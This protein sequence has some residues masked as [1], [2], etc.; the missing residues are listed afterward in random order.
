MRRLSLILGS[1]L[2][3]VLV[4]PVAADTTGPSDPPPAFSTGGTTVQITGYHL[5]AKLVVEIDLAVTCQPKAPSVYPLDTFWQ[6]TS[7]G[8]WAKQANGRSI[9]FGTNGFSFD[10]DTVCDGTPHSMVATTSADS[11]GVPFKNGAAV[12]AAT[13]NASWSSNNEETFEFLN[14]YAAASTGWVKVKLGK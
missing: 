6:D 3:I 10:G 2:A 12:I 13:A 14:Y 4:A 8:I 11:S 1:I 9:A 7:F 5:T